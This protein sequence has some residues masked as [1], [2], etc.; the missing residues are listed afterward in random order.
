MTWTAPEITRTK[1][2][3]VGTEREI[4]EGYL[5]WHRQTLLVKCAGLTAE[6]LKLASVEPSTLTL[7]GLVRH[8]AEVERWWFRTN[9]VGEPDSNIYCS[10]DNEDGDFDDVP[11]ADAE[12][13]VATFL[14]EVEAARKAVADLSLEHTF[15]TRRGAPMTLRWVFL[16]MLEEYA[17]HNGHADLL[18]QRID[19]AVGQ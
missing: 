6:Q 9:A 15:T 17:R 10:D 4:V 12:A 19:G 11:T 18:R 8:M 1:E 2:P 5:D 16:H 3:Y 13:D 14:A 7:L